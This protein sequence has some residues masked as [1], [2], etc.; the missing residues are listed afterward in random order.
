MRQLWA[1]AL[2]ATAAAFELASFT[3]S[4]GEGLITLTFDEAVQSRTLNASGIVLQSNATAERAPMQR[5]RLR[6]AHPTL[7]QFL[8][9]TPYNTTE[10]LTLVM[11]DDD[12][13]EV[14]ALSDLAID[15]KS[16]WL[17][18]EEGLARAVSDNDRSAA[19]T[20]PL[21]VDTYVPDTL[22]SE[23]ELYTIDMH[24]G[25]ICFKF[26][27][28]VDRASLDLSGVILQTDVNVLDVDTGY[29]CRNVDQDSCVQLTLVN[30]ESKLLDIP[31]KPT[32]VSSTNNDSVT[33]W[34]VV[35]LNTTTV[36][37]S[38]WLN[39]SLGPKNL[40]AIK[41]AY[42]LGSQAHL[43]NLA[44]S[45]PIANDRGGNAFLTIS[46]R[47][48][49]ALTPESW[50]GDQNR[51]ILTSFAVDMDSGQIDL[52]FNE[53]V[54][55]NE[56]DVTC[57]SLHETRDNRTGGLFHYLRSYGPQGARTKG[58][59]VSTGDGPTLVIQM[60]REDSDEI[61]R[62]PRLLTGRDTSF[63]ALD[64][65]ETYRDNAFPVNFGIRRSR[66]DALQAEVFVPDTTRPVLTSAS[67]DLDVKILTLEFD[68]TVNA[69]SLIVDYLQVQSTERD[70]SYTERV[71]LES[72]VTAGDIRHDRMSRRGS[73]RISPAGS[74]V[75]IAIG[76]RDFAAMKLA[77]T[78]GSDATSTF[79]AALGGAVLDMLPKDELSTL[80]DDCLLYTSPSPRD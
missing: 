28:P 56:L 4:A 37:D 17:V 66:V 41:A 71:Q 52:T 61:K 6:G 68:E 64:C 27:E 11:R 39:V 26:L 24:E 35:C 43:T 59:L 58:S 34:S 42:P 1:A 5:F 69:S 60:S 15:A 14:Q 74:N 32:N 53:T 78:F 29:E 19:I 9:T 44:L 23:M 16:V 47:P 76:D 45:A 70:L 10:T 33:T 79:V 38:L 30:E 54:N 73:G 65:D 22:Q 36:E 46:L 72:Y 21:E 31:C 77:T 20:K 48:E 8:Y 80:G 50:I 55:A 57:V 51:P 3:Y 25:L 40:N 62:K 2:V 18:A 67:L 63:V 49:M 75:S 12:L 13:L 7:G